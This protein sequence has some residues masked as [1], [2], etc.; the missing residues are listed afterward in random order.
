MTPHRGESDEL[1]VLRAL[2]GEC[3][4][5]RTIGILSPT[6]KAGVAESR[7]TVGPQLGVF[8]RGDAVHGRREL[9]WAAVAVASRQRRSIPEVNERGKW[10]EE[11]P[12]NGYSNIR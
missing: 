4:V 10:K 1:F 2:E 12:G 9:G 8:W 11:D 3:L 6:Q 7:C 5:G